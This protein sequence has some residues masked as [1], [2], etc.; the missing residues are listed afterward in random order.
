[1]KRLALQ[2]ADREPRIDVLINNAGALFGR[3]RLT[4][5]GLE[6]TFALNHMAYFLLTAGLREA[7]SRDREW[8]HPQ[9]S[10]P[11]LSLREKVERERANVAK[12][13]QLAADPELS[14]PAA[15]FARNMARSSQGLGEKALAYQNH[16]RARLDEAS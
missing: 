4:E 6:H 11:V 7:Q 12:W 16:S 9:Q 5:D 2:I 14:R 1:M 10:Q 3:H 13:N 8:K 15:L